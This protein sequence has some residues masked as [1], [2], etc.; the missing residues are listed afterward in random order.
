VWYTP[1][2]IANY[3]VERVHRHLIEDLGFAQG[4]ADESVIVLDPACGTGTYLAAVLRR[5]M[6]YHLEN[7][8]APAEAAREL[9][10]AALQRI[11]GF[12]ILPAALIVA[13]I[14]LAR[15]L[16][17][18][19]AT[20]QP[21]ERLRCYLTNSLLGWGTSRTPAGVPLAD[22]LDEIRHA[23]DV[24]ASEPVI[25]VLGNPPYEGYSDAETDEEKDILKA[26]TEDLRQ[27]WG[28]KKHRCGD[29]YV[30]FWRIAVL[31]IA[32]MEGRGV[33]SFIT[34]RKWLGGR[35]F[36]IM[37]E[38]I[39][40]Q[41]EDVIVDDLHGDVHETDQSGDGSV[42]TTAT[43]PGIQRGVA[44]VTVIRTGAP[45]AGSV[46][47]V[48]HRSLRG[49]GAEKRAEM[50]SLAASDEIDAGLT[51]VAVTRT[52]RWKLVP[53]EEAEYPIL[54]E[55]FEFI[56]SGVQDLSMGVGADFDRQTLER[57]IRAIYD[58]EMTYDEVVTAYPEATGLGEARRN[59]LAGTPF[60]DE[61]LVPFLYRPFDLRW[62]YWEQTNQTLLHRPRTDL[63]P[64]NQIPGQRYIVCPQTVRRP[65]AARPLLTTAIACNEAVDPN[66]RVVPLLS[67]EYG[68]G[69]ET[70]RRQTSID[71]GASR[72]VSNLSEPW[73]RAAAVAGVEGDDLE[74]GDIV[75]H[76]M[77]AVMFSPEWVSAVDLDSDD[78]P[79]V[80]LPGDLD[81][82]LEAARLGHRLF[83]LCDVVRDVD[84]ISRGRLE[85]EVA[86]IGVPFGDD[87]RVAIGSSRHAGRWE[88]TGDRVG[89][90]YVSE[91][92]G[93]GGVPQDIWEYE[94]GG[95]QVLSKWLSYRCNQDL[96]AD[97][98]RY[99]SGL[100]R[101]LCAIRLLEGACDDVA[102]AARRTPLEIVAPVETDN[103]S[104]DATSG[105][106]V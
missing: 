94:S 44:I 9:R 77:A 91:T 104:E 13:H 54:S 85:P 83:D 5:I 30:R 81:A 87:H 100:L 45:V 97:D 79:E 42:F 106:L 11:V 52:T 19:G 2:E 28:V 37:R 26:W 24:K 35:S 82:L 70:G 67:W 46:A 14:N 103:R 50:V 34:N 31:K 72:V 65:D 15:E 10:T 41:F 74:V 63:V 8:L 23:Q 71:F 86:S 57:R 59:R 89:R 43:A 64:Y 101:R 69:V 18:Q 80:P 68:A 102:A 16:R 78:F 95:W 38:A 105:L 48:R 93:W 22:F 20:L 47:R 84:G 51:D 27:V 56:T 61:R 40:T 66:A 92:S 21:T 55:Y 12:D 29:L 17:R 36:P 99:V 25:V 58:G 76:A 39:C 75:F 32:E 96:S 49:S 4:L 98:V 1:A 33:I 3:Q 7:N 60:R 90:I 53:T 6:R 88:S 62:L 73:I